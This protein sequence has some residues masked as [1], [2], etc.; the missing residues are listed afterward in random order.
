M[1]E[2]R[3]KEEG[4]RGARKCS[5]YSPLRSAPECSC[6]GFMERG[7]RGERGGAV[8]VG[9]GCGVGESKGGEV[10]VERI[11]FASARAEEDGRGEEL[12]G[13]AN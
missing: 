10:E 2:R 5:C 13:L 4:G 3:E 11:V 6:C 7:E 9:I 1:W 12:G 8:G